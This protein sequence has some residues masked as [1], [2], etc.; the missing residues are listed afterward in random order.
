MP[1]PT[2]GN[3][4]TVGKLS[5]DG[6]RLGRFILGRYYDKWKLVVSRVQP[7]R[8]S[9]VLKGLVRVLL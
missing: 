2:V 8:V 3:L 6:S 4:P 1:V 5:T 7:L 9:A